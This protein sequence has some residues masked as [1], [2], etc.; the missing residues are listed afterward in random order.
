MLQQDTDYL[1]LCALQLSSPHSYSYESM[2]RNMSVS[3]SL[4]LRNRGFQSDK[5]SL[6]S[7]RYCP[8][9]NTMSLKKGRSSAAFHWD[10]SDTIEL[11]NQ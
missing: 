2:P 6:M 11:R 8:Y 4:S 10:A 1:S 3:R 9:L 7:T 5:F